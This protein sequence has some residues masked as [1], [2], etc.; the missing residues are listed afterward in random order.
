MTCMEMNSTKT[1]KSYLTLYLKY[2]TYISVPPNRA[3]IHDVYGNEFNQ[4]LGPFQLNSSVVLVCD[5]LGGN[6]IFYKMQ[7]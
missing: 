1:Y 6:V 5:I 3:V 7:L 4:V 2:S